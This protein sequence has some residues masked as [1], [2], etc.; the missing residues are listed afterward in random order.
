MAVKL[1]GN[2]F[3]EPGTPHYE[4]HSYM[5]SFWNQYRRGGINAG[6]M[7]TNLE[8]SNAML[9][10]VKKSGLNHS[11]AMQI[12][13]EA[14]KQRVDYGLLGGMEVPRLPGKINQTGR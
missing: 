6:K 9:K 3:T 1:E 2:A 8:Y 4:T 7:P 14:I 13:K 12:M 11:Q 10:A 5:E